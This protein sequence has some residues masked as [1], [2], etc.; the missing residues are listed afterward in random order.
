MAAQ[1]GAGEPTPGHSPSQPKRRGRYRFRR[2]KAALPRSPPLSRGTAMGL[3]FRVCVGLLPA[4]R[5]G[6]GTGRPGYGE[7]EQ[8]ASPLPMSSSRVPGLHRAAPSL[9][10]EVPPHPGIPTGRAAVG[11]A[12]RPRALTAP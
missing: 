2:L 9:T 11:S 5:V 10:A 3:H 6:R 1:A 12:V 8:P 4:A 7:A